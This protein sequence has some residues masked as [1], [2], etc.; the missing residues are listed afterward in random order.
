MVFWNTQMSLKGTQT[1]N[2]SINSTQIPIEKLLR[3]P[4][5]I[6]REHRTLRDVLTKKKNCSS[7]GFWPNP[8]PPPPPPPAKKTKLHKQALLQHQYNKKLS[9]NHWV[10]ALFEISGSVRRKYLGKQVTET[11]KL[12]LK[13]KIFAR[14]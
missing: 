6:S 10:I 12:G 9:K 5:D 11:P 7:F 8:P 2:T 14:L 4:P 3:H 13:L 1:S